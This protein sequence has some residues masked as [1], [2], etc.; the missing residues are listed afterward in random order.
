MSKLYRNF[1]KNFKNK[2]LNNGEKVV[3]GD[4]NLEDFSAL[5]L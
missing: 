5:Y 2:L 3:I 1:E 4:N